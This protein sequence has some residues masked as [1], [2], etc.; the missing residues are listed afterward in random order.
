MAEL[1]YPY[2]ALGITMLNGNVSSSKSIAGINLPALDTEAN[3]NAT[4][5]DLE[6]IGKMFTRATMRTFRQAKL[7]T[8]EEVSG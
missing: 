2:Y 6:V 4:A 3:R 5:Y 8:T 7:T 1:G